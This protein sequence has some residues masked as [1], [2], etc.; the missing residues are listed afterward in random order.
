[1]KRQSRKKKR[2]KDKKETGWMK[3]FD[4]IGDVLEIVMEIIWK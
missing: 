3:A 1:M 4:L 2:Q